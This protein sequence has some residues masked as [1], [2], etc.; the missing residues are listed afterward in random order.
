MNTVLLYLQTSLCLQ[1]QGI[2]VTV[3]VGH[4]DLDV[5]LKACAHDRYLLE[6]SA[7]K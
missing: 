6:G 5:L 7:L 4:V 1:K 3:I 2:Q